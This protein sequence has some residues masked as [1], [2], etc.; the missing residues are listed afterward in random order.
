MERAKRSSDRLLE[1]Y[2]IIYDPDWAVHKPQALQINVNIDEFRAE[3][4]QQPTEVIEAY[5]EK[6]QAELEQG[7]IIDAELA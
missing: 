2:S 7:D 6:K 5:V 1:K 3:L 4:A